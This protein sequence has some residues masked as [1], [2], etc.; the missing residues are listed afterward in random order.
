MYSI[1]DDHD[2]GTN[3]CVPGSEIESP[4]RKRKGWEIFRQNWVSP[5]YGHGEEPPGCWYDFEIADV[6][7]MMLDGR[8]YRDRKGKTMLGSVQM[9]WLKETLVN[10][11]AIFKVLASPVPWTAGVKPGSRDPWDGYP[12]E[13]EEIFSFIENEG[14][15]G[16]FLIAADR[17][18]TDVRVTDEG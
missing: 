2:F 3:D 13:R 8:Y 15:E 14:V 11:Q 18:R 17:H 9:R 16:V 5:G 10:S 6:H 1:Y 7:F 4:P 12:E